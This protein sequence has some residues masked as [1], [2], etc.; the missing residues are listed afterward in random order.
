MKKVEVNKVA[1][2]NGIFIDQSSADNSQYNL[3]SLL[4]EILKRFCITET[5]DD[6]ILDT[7]SSFPEYQQLVEFENLSKLKA[8][9]QQFTEEVQTLFG[10]K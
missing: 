5:I 9:V 3:I 6:H 4:D 7:K 2:F 1:N 8:N 10:K